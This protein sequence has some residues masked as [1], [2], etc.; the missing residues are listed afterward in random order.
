MSH[1]ILV[2]GGAKSGKSAFAET[3][4]TRFDG[5]K[6]YLA[7]AQSHDDEMTQRINEH[8]ARRDATWQT[9]NVPLDLVSALA[10][11]NQPEKI[12][13]LDC[14]TLWISNL[15]MNERNFDEALSALLAQ[16]K[17]MQAT[18]IIVSNEVGHGIV[19]DNKMARLFRDQSGI[20]H[21]KIAALCD[22]A[23]FLTA[24]LPQKLKG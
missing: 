9:I 4:C 5:Q 8:Q 23:Y 11:H 17:T 20:A 2:L 16:I 6:I 19:P 12:I 15:M 13:L 22:Q 3:L 10:D 7:T 24:G 18:L 14:L 1:K 21:Q